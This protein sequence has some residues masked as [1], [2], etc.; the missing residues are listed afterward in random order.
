VQVVVATPTRLHGGL[1]VNAASI[2]AQNFPQQDITWIVVDEFWQ[3]RHDEVMACAAAY[4]F[5]TIHVAGPPKRP[6]AWNNLEASYN[7]A[8]DIARHLDV[9][10]FVS[11]QDYFW[12]P[13][14]GL[15]RFALMAALYENDLYT[16]LASLARDPGPETVA[17]R[18]GGWT[19][20]DKPWV[21]K[22]PE[23]IK[24]HDVREDQGL[25]TEPWETVPINWELNWAAWPKRI[26][27]S[28]LD[29]D[30]EYDRG[31]GYGNQD[32][33]L[34]AT[35]DHGSRIMLDPLNHSIGLPHKAYFPMVEKVEL[36]RNNEAF[37]LARW[38]I[39]E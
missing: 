17:N 6:G 30:V 13:R 37:H 9:D 1:D 32:F 11:M 29:F 19:I 34:R 28:G 5:N 12:I 15:M 8:L 36:S 33:A 10:L 23:S 26:L 16:G 24:W 27:M 20:Y 14:D 18:E 7:L 38:V 21:Y 22:R 39:Y 4:E 35:R 25:P 31:V 3:E 2:A